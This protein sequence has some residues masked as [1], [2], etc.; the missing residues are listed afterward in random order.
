M[1]SKKD[2]VSTLDIHGVS[3]RE[4]K[5][6]YWYVTHRELLEKAL[7]SVLFL[8]AIFCWIFVGFRFVQFYILEPDFFQEMQMAIMTPRVD[9]E[10]YQTR[11]FP[12]APIP[13]EVF[14]ISTG[15][16][17]YDLLAKIK[18]PNKDW[19]IESLTYQ[20]LFNNISTEPLSA[21]ILPGKERYLIHLGVNS[22]SRIEGAALRI[23]D[24]R[25]K[26]IQ[27]L[28]LKEFAPYE[29]ERFQVSIENANYISSQVL[30]ISEKV[31][32]SRGSFR[33]TNLS[34]YNFWNMGFLVLLTQNK[35]II[36]VAYTTSGVFPS[37]LPR[38]LEVSWFERLPT[39]AQ[40]E[41][42]PEVD[43]L[44]QTVYMDY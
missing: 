22:E 14:V 35:K 39:F 3:A 17:H 6:S 28:G 9:F 36:S 4:L 16:N 29:N 34:N 37:L 15:S 41:I 38:F 1:P 2:P 12:K 43:V 27:S 20:F 21:Y 31:P 11:Y 18:N 42:I 24:I 5:W 30:G 32:I 33:A 44:D 8:I 7:K 25:W 13:L 40:M 23:T 10:A 19:Y 26:K